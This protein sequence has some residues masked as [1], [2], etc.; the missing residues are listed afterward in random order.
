MH[1]SHVKHKVRLQIELLLAHITFYPFGV[2]HLHHMP[3][4]LIVILKSRFADLAHAITS[5]AFMFR[6]NMG[7]PFRFSCE[8][9][10]TMSTWEA[11]LFL[12]VCGLMS[13]Q[14]EA[15]NKP[16][17]TCGTNEVSIV[18]VHMLH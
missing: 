10:S 6:V 1:P 17:T 3:R 2:M 5:Y 18:N 16:S 9:L 11:R 8:D 15:V 12:S 4:L 7:F 14:T 13:I